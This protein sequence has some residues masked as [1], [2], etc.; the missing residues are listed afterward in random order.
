MLKQ[1]LK[2]R[3]KPASSRRSDTESALY[4]SLFEFLIGCITVPANAEQLIQLVSK[5]FGKESEE[6]FHTYLMSFV[7]HVILDYQLI[8]EVHSVSPLPEQFSVFVC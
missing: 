8:H 7:V 5:A 6:V 1:L 4:K 3:G 2:G